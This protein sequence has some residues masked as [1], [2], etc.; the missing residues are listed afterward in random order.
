MWVNACIIKLYIVYIV[1]I[2]TCICYLLII[3]VCVV[4]CPVRAHY[5]KNNIFYSVLFYSI[6]LQDSFKLIIA[7]GRRFSHQDCSHACV[8]APQKR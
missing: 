5:G 3:I 6:I 7:R 4:V 1:Y 8:D 2:A